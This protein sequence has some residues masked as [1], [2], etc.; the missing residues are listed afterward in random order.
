MI[1]ARSKVNAFVIRYR[2]AEASKK[3]LIVSQNKSLA[4]FVGTEFLSL[5][6]YTAPGINLD[7]AAANGVRG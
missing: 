6:I 4:S 1:K 5:T 3:Q 2:L 7:L